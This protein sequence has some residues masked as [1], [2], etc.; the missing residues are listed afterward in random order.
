MVREESHPLQAA[1]VAA[2]QQ[3]VARTIS[4]LE[5]KIDDAAA[6]KPEAIDLALS[7]V[8]IIDSAGLNW[9]LATQA[10]LEAQ[11]TKLRLVDLSPIMADALLATR[12]DTRLVVPSKNG[13]DELMPAGAGG[14]V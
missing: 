9:L 6:S 4:L 2:A 12:L 3:I 1:T 10:R 5:R 11:G 7:A 14:G 13:V 8:Q